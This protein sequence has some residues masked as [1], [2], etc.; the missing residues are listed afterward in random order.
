MQEV[1]CRQV[2]SISEPER[3]SDACAPVWIVLHS[4][5]GGVM[6]G[7]FNLKKTIESIGAYREAHRISIRGVSYRYLRPPPLLP[8]RHTHTHTRTLPPHQ[9]H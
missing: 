4:P 7:N 3:S 8:P 9:P 5:D 1:R 2:W 6:Q